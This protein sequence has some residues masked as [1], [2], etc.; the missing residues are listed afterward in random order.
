MYFWRTYNGGEVNLVEEKGGKL[1]GYEFK[2]GAGKD[3]RPP[4]LWI[5]Y[6]Q[7]TYQIINKEKLSG[8]VF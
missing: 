7:S 5:S 8:F 1:N 3:R 6:P 2:W 4:T